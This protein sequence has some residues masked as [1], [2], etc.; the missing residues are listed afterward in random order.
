VASDI[1]VIA[2]VHG[3]SWALEAVLAD[4]KRRAI[5]ITINL[6]DSVWGPLDP[7]GTADRLKEWGTINVRGNSDRLL[8]APTEDIRANPSFEFVTARLTLAHWSWLQAHVPTYVHQ[9]L[10]CCHG[11]P[12][13]DETI[14]LEDVRPTGISLASDGVIASH[15]ADVPQPVVL[16]GHTHISRTVRLRDGRL[17]VNP[18]SVGIQAFTETSPFPQAWET[19]SPHARYAILSGGPGGYTVEHVALPYAWDHAAAAARRH[20]RPDYAAWIASGRATMS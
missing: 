20:G 2:D 14:L 9:D 11:G 10:F 3:N 7:A 6:G 17:I 1:A 8:V 5:P 4:I 18:G 15:V 12:A 13:S 19:G 16:C